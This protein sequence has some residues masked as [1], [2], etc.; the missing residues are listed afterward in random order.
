[1]LGFELPT[2]PVSVED[3]A[4]IEYL[5]FQANAVL[6]EADGAIIPQGIFEVSAA[7]KSAQGRTGINC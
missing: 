1:V 2:T 4:Q 3:N 6:D 7:T 5:S